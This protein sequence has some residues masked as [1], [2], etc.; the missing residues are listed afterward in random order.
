MISYRVR[1]HALS[2][3]V[4]MSYMNSMYFYVVSVQYPS[5]LCFLIFPDLPWSWIPPPDMSWWPDVTWQGHSKLFSHIFS[6]DGSENSHWNSWNSDWNTIWIKKHKKYNENNYNTIH[7]ND[8]LHDIHDTKNTSL[9]F[10]FTHFTLSEFLLLQSLL[11]ILQI[12]QCE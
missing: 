11:D 12:L 7:Y 4:M 9:W 6:A 8:T 3:A 10:S 2:C 1:Y 5:D